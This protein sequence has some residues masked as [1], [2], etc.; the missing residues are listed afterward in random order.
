MILPTMIVRLLLA[1]TTNVPR[2]LRYNELASL[3]EGLLTSTTALES[4]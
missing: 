4:L 2:E 1:K 3:P